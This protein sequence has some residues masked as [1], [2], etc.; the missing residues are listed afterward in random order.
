MTTANPVDI[1]PKTYNKAYS[2]I[3]GRIKDNTLV[4]NIESYLE[5]S[6]SI[7]DYV[8]LNNVLDSWKPF[9]KQFE[10]ETIND[11]VSITE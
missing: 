7:C 8:L 10:R 9:E 4:E 5:N 1:S 11:F 2:M 3:R 6:S